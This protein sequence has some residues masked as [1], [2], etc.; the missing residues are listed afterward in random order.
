MHKLLFHSV[1][2]CLSSTRM[3]LVRQQ[4]SEN[5]QT[6]AYVRA[7]VLEWAGPHVTIGTRIFLGKSFC[8]EC[9]QAIKPRLLIMR[10]VW[11][12]EEANWY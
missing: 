1:V 7:T 5:E 12:G 11:P 9:N 2:A 8:R 6:K 4:T 10:G 3:L